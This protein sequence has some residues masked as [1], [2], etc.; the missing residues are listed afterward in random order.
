MLQHNTASAA[1]LRR[2]R[3]KRESGPQGRQSIARGA[4]P[5]IA[6][7]SP[8][9]QLR[10]SDRR[11]NSTRGVIGKY[12]HVAQASVSFHALGLTRLRNVLVLVAFYSRESFTASPLRGFPVCWLVF[13][14]LAPLAINCRPSG[15]IDDAARLSAILKKF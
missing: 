10:R 4:S 14:G 1:T 6:G 7:P 13:Q 2:H 11:L 3:Q 15:A 9:V 5:W 8:V 12:K